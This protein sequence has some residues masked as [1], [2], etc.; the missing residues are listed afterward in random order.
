MAIFKNYNKIV[1]K[2]EKKTKNATEMPTIKTL[3]LSL[4]IHFISTLLYLHYIVVL[5]LL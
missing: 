1:E 3:D 5:T 2:N 4:Y